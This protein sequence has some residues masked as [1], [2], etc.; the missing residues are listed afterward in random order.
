MQRVGAVSSEQDS[1]TIALA[2]RISAYIA[3]HPNAADTIE[4]ISWWFVR[5]EYEEALPKLKNAMAY[6]LNNGQIIERRVA[7]KVIYQAGPHSHKGE[8]SISQNGSH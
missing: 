7:D 5:Q 1:E 8:V 2:K 4:G 6:L 3:A